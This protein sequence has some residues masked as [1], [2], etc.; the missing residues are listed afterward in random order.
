MDVGE[1]IKELR[2]GKGMSQEVLGKLIGES[3]HSICTYEK[4][5]VKPTDRALKRIAKIF[6]IRQ[7]VLLN[8]ASLEE[9]E[10]NYY[11]N[12]YLELMHTLSS[13]CTQIT[14]YDNSKKICRFQV[15]IN[16][17]GEILL[18]PNTE[19]NCTVKGY[20]RRKETLDGTLICQTVNLK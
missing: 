6:G 17:N 16:K 19:E 11:K 20:K 5:V 15:C 2:R 9:N 3:G 14:V 12:K 1:K 8:D 7:E 4:G 13:T 10:I 18:K